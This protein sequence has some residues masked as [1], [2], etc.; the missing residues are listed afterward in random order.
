GARYGFEP[1]KRVVNLVLKERF[2]SWNG[3]GSLSMATRGGRWGERVSAGR[4]LIAGDLRWN[5]QTSASHESRLLKSERT[6]PHEQ[7]DKW[8]ALAGLEPQRYE[9][10]LPSA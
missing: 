7:E 9:T 1:G 2:E 4:F 5:V 6:V 3:E 10:L 8:A